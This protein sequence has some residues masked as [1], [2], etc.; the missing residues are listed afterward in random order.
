MK[1]I[2]IKPGRCVNPV[3]SVSEK[4]AALQARMPYEVPQ[5]L[6]VPEGTEHDD[7][8][9]WVLCVKGEATPADAECSARVLK[10]IGAPGRQKLIADIKA[11]RA[12]DGVQ[13]LS[14]KERRWL[15]M[16]ESAYAVEL[17]LA[18]APVV[19][20]PAPVDLPATAPESVT[21]D[22]VSPIAESPAASVPNAAESVALVPEV[23]AAV[24]DPGHAMEP[25]RE[26]TVADILAM[27]QG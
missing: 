3:F 25:V 19:A 2:R 26:L 8:H 10:H 15:D 7:P 5:F 16:M 20:I 13:R 11:L 12:A 27:N 17:G 24:P 4:R 6:T 14:V 9:A 23:P 22:R 1:A 21:V 18:E